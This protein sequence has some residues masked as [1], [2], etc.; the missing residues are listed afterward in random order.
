M[1]FTK[2]HGAGND[3]ILLDNR[4]GALQKYL[5]A[6][7]IQ[8]IC[9][10]HEGIGADGVIVM[11]RH[12]QADFSMLFFNDDGGTA[13]M[14][15]N[16]ARC[17][18]RYAHDHAQVPARMAFLTAAGTVNA[19]ILPD[20]QVA[21]ELPPPHS[22]R[23]SIKPPEY[24]GTV[25]TINTGVPHAVVFT[26]SFEGIDLIELGRIIRH[27]TAF[28]PEGTNVNLAMQTA[29]NRL[30]V[31]TYERGVEGETLACGTGI[32]AC[33]LLAHLRIGI[34]PPILVECAHGDVL[35]VG[36]EYKN[37]TFTRVRLEGPAAYCF[38][39]TIDDE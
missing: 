15:G 36:F 29:D 33:A 5:C 31:R 12:E 21:I 3:F 27:S 16:A 13:A 20:G 14:C 17:L 1:K 28:A 9:Q 7:W 24:H 10:R 39:G 34:R 6:P 4:D 37:E 22:I 32:V 23:R 38:T 19:E 30:A 8:H 26:Q 25:D 11:N 18:A 35:R 2:M